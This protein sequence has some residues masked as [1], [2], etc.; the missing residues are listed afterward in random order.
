VTSFTLER[1]EAVAPRSGI[2]RTAHG[3]AQTPAF[4]PVGTAGSV[5]GLSP[6]EIRAAGTQISSRTPT[7]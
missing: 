2:L 7:I 5:K 4:M 3:V 1:G 6:A